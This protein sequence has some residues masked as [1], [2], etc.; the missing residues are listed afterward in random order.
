MENGTSEYKVKLI[1]AMKFLVE[2]LL[3]NPRGGNGSIR[4][5]EYVWITP[6]GIPKNKLKPHDL[7]LYDMKTKKFKGFYKPSIEY[8]IHVMTYENIGEAKAVLH[9]HLPLATGIAS[10][11]GVD[12]VYETFSE[13]EYSTGKVELVDPA[14]PGSLELARNVVNAFINGA[15]TVIVPRHG[16]FAWGRNVEEALDAIV[17]LENAA[18][19]YIARVLLVKML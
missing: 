10:V 18:K 17:G 16:V 19:Y 7:V 6:S 11:N 5:N 12:W 8:R 13:I 3:T 15:R 4:I 14:P 1:G 2:T 9:A